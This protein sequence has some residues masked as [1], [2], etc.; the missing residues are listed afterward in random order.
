MSGLHSAT[1]AVF[2][3]LS[4]EIRSISGNSGCVSFVARSIGTCDSE[5]AES[6]SSKFTRCDALV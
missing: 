5:F 1:A 3:K 4:A 2:A 6:S